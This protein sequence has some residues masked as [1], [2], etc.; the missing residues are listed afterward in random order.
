MAARNDQSLIGAHSI[1]IGSGSGR[2]LADDRAAIVSPRSGG[3]GFEA[4][5]EA[6]STVAEIP[7]EL[8]LRRSPLCPL[9][10]KF[11]KFFI[12]ITSPNSRF[13]IA[14]FHEFSRGD[15]LQKLGSAKLFEPKFG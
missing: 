6:V 13:L 8:P 12:Q 3:S 15:D 1:V 5:P 2:R 14:V 9:L 10:H 4:R 7:A 11:V